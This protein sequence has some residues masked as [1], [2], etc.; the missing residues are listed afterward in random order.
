MDNK[1]TTDNSNIKITT[2]IKCEYFD[3][4]WVKCTKNHNPNP[5]YNEW[6]CAEG[7]PKQK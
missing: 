3:D 5:P 2:C 7:K 4:Y 6:Y 1:E